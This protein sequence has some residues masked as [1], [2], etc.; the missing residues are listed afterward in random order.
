MVTLQDWAD[1]MAAVGRS[2]NTI[3]LRVVAVSRLCSM[4]DLADPTV[5][6]RLDVISFLGQPWKPWTRLTYW[7]SIDAWGR[8]VR[9]FGD[10]PDFDP[11]KGIDR[12]KTPEGVARPITDAEVRRLLASR[13]HWRTRAYVLLALFQGLRVHEI[14]KI[15]AEDTDLV[16]GWLRVL[17]KGGIEKTVPL[18]P[19]VLAMAEATLPLRGWWFPARSG[20]GPVTGARVSDTIAQAMNRAGIN[21]TAHQLRDTA[22]TRVQRMSHDIRVTQTFLRHKRI[23]STQKYTAVDDEALRTAVAGLNWLEAA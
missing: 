17:G 5:M 7:A 22:A 9:E 8:F 10:N 4:R 6:T 12:P 18:H 20:V 23:T 15:S 16:S 3:R 11:T 1:Y 13:M 14:A 19:E 2:Q 21:A